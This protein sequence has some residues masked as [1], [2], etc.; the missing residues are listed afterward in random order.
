MTEQ[1]WQLLMY[2][3]I[4]FDILKHSFNLSKTR[5]MFFTLS[6]EQTLRNKELLKHT[7]FMFFQLIKYYFNNTIFLQY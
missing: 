3:Q 7:E 2:S 4:Y 1:T 6:G 5:K